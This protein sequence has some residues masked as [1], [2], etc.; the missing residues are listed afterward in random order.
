VDWECLVSGV[1]A[2]DR[3]REDHVSMVE[4]KL[5]V[6]VCTRN[7]AGF[8]PTALSYYEKITAS[9]PWELV[10]VDNASSDETQSVLRNFGARAAIDF[11]SVL[12]PRIGLS[13][14][15]NTGWQHARGEIIAFT[16]D[17][18]YPQQDFVDEVW[19]NFTE[20][21]LA[22]LGGRILLYDPAD[23]P[24]TIQLRDQRL[25]IDPLT[26]IHA[27]LIQGA[28][29]AARRDVLQKL[30]GFDEMLGA[31]TA[32]PSEDV[33]F[34]SRAS[35]AGLTGAYDPRPVVRHHH[36]RRTKKQVAALRRSYALGRGAYYMKCVLDPLQRS[37][38]MRNWYWILLNNPNGGLASLY[39]MVGAS[40]YLL[41]RT[42]GW[43]RH[44]R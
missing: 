25:V 30:G 35:S 15:R 8:L 26:Y 18:C 5:S 19:Q 32:F 20:T 7:R 38:G 14:A 39:E 13:R 28:N 33:D 17:D 12:E 23:Y 2:I 36:R 3:L 10:V 24:I 42:I 29:M 6:V 37:R 16:D 44:G 40:T 31:G 41:R 43:A 9:V 22:Y 1:A 4:P 11:H 27:G 21:P 34:I